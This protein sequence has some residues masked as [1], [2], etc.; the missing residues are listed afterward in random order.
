[1]RFL[2]AVVNYLYDCG[3]GGGG[4]SG[5]NVWENKLVFVM[6]TSDIIYFYY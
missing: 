5:L 2:Y 4:G 3:R 6:P 1:M